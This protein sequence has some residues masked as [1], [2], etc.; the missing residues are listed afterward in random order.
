MEAW[1]LSEQKSPGL[2]IY[3]YWPTVPALERP[4]QEDWSPS[5]GYTVKL[6]VK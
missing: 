2:V 5:L 4:R 1:L 3:A 6:C